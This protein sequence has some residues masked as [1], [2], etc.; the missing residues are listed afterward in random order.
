MDAV[1]ITTLETKPIAFDLRPFSP[2]AEPGGAVVVTAA[3]GCSSR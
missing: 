2:G 3:I 1:A